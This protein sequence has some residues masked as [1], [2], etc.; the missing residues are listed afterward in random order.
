MSH[1]FVIGI[2]VLMVF[3]AYKWGDNPLQE[4]W[5]LIL[6]L[7]LFGWG[8]IAIVEVSR[9]L[10]LVIL[11]LGVATVPMA[12]AGSLLLVTGSFCLG[13]WGRR[14]GG[15]KPPYVIEPPRRRWLPLAH[16][17]RKLIGGGK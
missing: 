3:I 7:G 12:V 17:K 11:S 14:W 15:H 2:G 16:V 10:P 5:L 1:C 6:L 13:R 8:A 9:Q 4:P